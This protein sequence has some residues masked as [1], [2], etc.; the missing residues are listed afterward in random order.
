MSFKKSDDFG[1]IYSADPDRFKRKFPNI[2][3]WLSNIR[4]R[5]YSLEKNTLMLIATKEYL[6]DEFLIPR[7]EDSDNV[8][9]NSL[10]ELIKDKP[11]EQQVSILAFFLLNA[12]LTFVDASNDT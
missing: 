4:R 2:H 3:K 8:P 1:Y 12:Q 9:H 10:Y 7:N 6:L 11:I 5:R